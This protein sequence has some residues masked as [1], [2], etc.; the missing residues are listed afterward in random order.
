MAFSW[1]CPFCNHKA[2]IQD[3]N[4]SSGRHEF[5]CGNK[6]GWQ[7]VKIHVIACPNEEC[8]EYTL[9]VSLHDH[10]MV[11]GQS[12]KDLDAKKVWH[13][14]PQSETKVFP[15]YV[16]KAILDDYAESCAIRDLSP[17][18]AAT[19]ARRCLQGMIREFWGVKKGRLIDEIE[20]IEDKVDPVTWAAIDAVRKIGN[21]GAHMES[22]IN[23][24]IDVEPQEAGL[25]IGLI[26]TLINDW[27][28]VREERKKRME[29]IVSVAAAK[30]ESKKP[31]DA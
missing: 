25:L 13:L 9:A 6:Y 18:A 21:I 8:K 17:K 12:Y 19:L 16:P 2:T 29:A 28:V 26:E 23:L 11:V 14:I 20:S 7:V 10:K 31:K 22:D 30:Q 15:E 27:Y 3:D 1:T 4:S 24:I 5:D